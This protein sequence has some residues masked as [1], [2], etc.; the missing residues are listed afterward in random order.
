MWHL[1]SLCA[2]LLPAQ[3]VP[4]CGGSF[5]LRYVRNVSS[6]S[7]LKPFKQDPKLETDL[8]NWVGRSMV[9][10]ILPLEELDSKVVLVLSS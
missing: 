3:L 7:L 4:G 9:A 2:S 1:M 5:T 10:L 6:P 8:K